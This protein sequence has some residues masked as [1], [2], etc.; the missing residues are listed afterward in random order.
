MSDPRTNGRQ[1]WSLYDRDPYW[2]ELW[3][4][5]HDPPQS[6]RGCGRPELLTGPSLAVIGTRRATPRG[7][8]LARG[9]AKAFAADGWVI[10]S[11]LALGIDGA[12]HRGAL[13]AGGRTVAVMANGID[14]TYPPAH[15]GLRRQIDKRGCTIT[16]RPDGAPPLRYEFPRRNRLVSGMC[17]ATIVVEAP[18]KSGALLTA[19]LA[20]DQNREVFAVPG[21]VDVENSRGCHHLLREGAHLLEAPADLRRIFAPPDGG[22][23][24]AQQIEPAD[25]LPA[26]GSSARWIWDRLDLDG[27]SIDK[28]RQRW[29]GTAAVWDQGLLALEMSG[30]IQVLP[31][32]RVARNIHFF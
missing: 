18:R 23:K 1:I 4:E 15:A 2:P 3:R 27:A 29:I 14:R 13:E 9:F 19:L 6:L 8:A 16:E 24:E 12:A 7:L 26:P 5:I 22:S 30:L 11:G 25:L 20:L 28:L 31:G 32:G 17:L 21:P 10:V